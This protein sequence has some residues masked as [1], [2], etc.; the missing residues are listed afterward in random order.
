MDCPVSLRS[1]DS[2]GQ[3]SLPQMQA[4]VT[5]TMASVGASMDGSGTFSIRTSPASY[6]SVARILRKPPVGDGVSVHD[7]RFRRSLTRRHSQGNIADAIGL[8][9]VHARDS[10][11]GRL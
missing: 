2:Y 4:R 10:G 5:R 7:E 8:R 11:P 1:I 9:R 6:I 3:R